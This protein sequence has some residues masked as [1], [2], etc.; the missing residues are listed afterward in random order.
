MVYSVNSLSPASNSKISESLQPHKIPHKNQG[1]FGKVKV[2]KKPTPSQAI[3]DLME[4]LSS[5]HSEHFESKKVEDHKEE[6][7]QFHNKYEKLIAQIEK[8][9][10][11]NEE[12]QKEHFH[13]FLSRL[14]ER[15]PKNQQDVAGMLADITKDKAEA[16]AL[17]H[18]AQ[19]DSK[20]LSLTLKTLLEKTQQT[21]AREDSIPIQAGINTL[22]LSRQTALTLNSSSVQL[23]ANYQNLVGS[24]QGILPALTHLAQDKQ[25]GNFQ[26]MTDYLMH[27]AATDLAATNPST[28]KQKLIHVLA[29]FQGI[30]VFN[31]LLDWSDKT[32]QRF[33]TVLEEKTS[34]TKPEL[35]HRTLKYIAKPEN[36]NEEI[37]SPLQ[38][39]SPK[40]KVLVLQELRSGV[41]N[42]PN[43]LFTN[44][45]T[46]KARALFP[47]QNEIDKLVFEEDA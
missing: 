33:Q 30:K 11:P 36:F 1:L 22:A 26:A 42:L 27:A 7:E 46:E 29:E 35:F 40:N 9:Y 25:L 23:Q 12:P 14:N 39:L 18:L 28:Q 8:E 15:E 21:M 47:L 3:E 17:L 45:E 2:H 19:K 20:T 5:A 38:P 41:R 16:F 4:E 37:K 6:E 32:H 34:L 31:T 13:E 43:Y 24:Y 44:G 10:P